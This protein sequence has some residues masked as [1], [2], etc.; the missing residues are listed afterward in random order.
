MNT[1]MKVS[2]DSMLVPRCIANFLV[3]HWL[4][5]HAKDDPDV[6]IVHPEDIEHEAL[7]HAHEHEDG[8]DDHDAQRIIQFARFGNFIEKN[9]PSK[10]L[11]P[12][13]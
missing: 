4:K 10:F 6:K 7:Y 1:N 9:V 11:K 2:K 5:Y 13:A 12:K 3:H 8:P